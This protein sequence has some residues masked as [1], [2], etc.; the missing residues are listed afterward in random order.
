MPPLE[1]RKVADKKR[2]KRPADDANVSRRSFI[3]SAAV[4]GGLTMLPLGG[5]LNASDSNPADYLKSPIQGTVIDSKQRDVPNGV[6]VEQVLEFLGANGKKDE[7]RIFLRTV[8]APDSYVVFVHKT[9]SLAN[10]SVAIVQYGEKGQV[11][12]NIRNDE[13]ET[14]IIGSDGSVRRMPATLVKVRLD[15]PYQGLSPNEK[16]QQLMKDKGMLGNFRPAE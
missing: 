9:S 11:D 14:T 4:L 15:Q 8:D 16:L 5:M 12:G 6:E 3:E 7:T 1:V 2:K 10:N 13:I